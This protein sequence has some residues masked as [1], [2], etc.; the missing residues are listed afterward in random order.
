MR[1]RLWASVMP[2]TQVW[3]LGRSRKRVRLS[4]LRLSCDMRPSR[5]R[6]PGRD[7]V[8]NGPAD[9]TEARSWLRPPRGQPEHHQAGRARDIE[10]PAQA[11]DGDA[12]EVAD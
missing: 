4:P 12:H 10:V 6:T 8:R 3:A 5:P 7:S 2:P 1:W 9:M 11:D